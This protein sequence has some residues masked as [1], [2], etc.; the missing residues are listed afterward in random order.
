MTAR[1]CV[2]AGPPSP[3]IGAVKGAVKGA[4]PGRDVRGCLRDVGWGI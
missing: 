4:V 3:E 2:A 1:T